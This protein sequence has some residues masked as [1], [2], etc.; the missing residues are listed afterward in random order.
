MVRAAL[1]AMFMEFGYCL[2]MSLVLSV[3]YRISRVTFH[4]NLPDWLPLFLPSLLVPCELGRWIFRPYKGR[5]V[6][7]IFTL[8][9]LHATIIFSEGVILWLVSRAGGA[10]HFNVF[11]VPLLVWN[12]KV[13]VTTASVTYYLS[14]YPMLMLAGAAAGRAPRGY[15]QADSLH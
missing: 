15:L 10:S 3:A 11:F 14:L 8:A 6:S 7:G 1:S 2:L 4:I 13:L 12:H 9:I 5:E